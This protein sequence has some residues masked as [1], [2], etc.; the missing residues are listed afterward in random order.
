CA[1]HSM[2]GAHHLV[3]RPAPAVGALPV[4]VLG[5]QLAPALLVHGA[6]AQE[7]VGVKQRV[8]GAMIRALGALRRRSLADAHGSTPPKSGPSAERRRAASPSPCRRATSC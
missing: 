5:H 4:A 2:G 1:I 8:A 6:S 7:P 3:V